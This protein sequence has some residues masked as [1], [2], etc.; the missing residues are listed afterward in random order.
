REEGRMWTMRTRE[1]SEASQIQQV[2]DNASGGYLTKPHF[3]VDDGYWEMR[4]AWWKETE[5]G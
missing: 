2:V 5:Y 1:P 3:V 4:K